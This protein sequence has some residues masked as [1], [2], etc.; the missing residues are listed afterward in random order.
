VQTDFPRL[1]EVFSAGRPIFEK[2]VRSSKAVPPHV[3]RVIEKCR[4]IHRRVNS[5]TEKPRKT[6]AVQ[7]RFGFIDQEFSAGLSSRTSGPHERNRFQMR[8]LW[9]FSPGGRC[10]LHPL[11]AR[12][13]QPEV[14]PHA[15]PLHLPRVRTQVLGTGRHLV[16]AK[17]AMVLAAG[18]K[19]SMPAL[20]V[21]SARSSEA[22]VHANPGSGNSGGRTCR[23]LRHSI[24]TGLSCGSTRCL[25]LP[26]RPAHAAT[27]AFGS[28][29]RAVHPR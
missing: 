14:R 22:Q 18:S 19:A 5:S 16:A 13:H 26:A 24:A 10:H 20:R 1:L 27:Q 6:T 28:R 17:G 2:H 8:G 7:V 25:G 29:V 15:G 9:R 23:D 21:S 12:T 3:K 4:V 11:R